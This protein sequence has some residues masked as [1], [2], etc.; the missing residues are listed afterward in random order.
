MLHDLKFA[1]RTLRTHPALACIVVVVL[2]LGIGAN[3][4]IFTLVNALLL[5]PPPH[6]Q[7]PHEL[8][9]LN[10]A[11]EYTVSGSFSY[12][13]YEFYRAHNVVFS[14][15]AAYGGDGVPVMARRGDVRLQASVM[16][17]SANFFEV[18]GVRAG[19]GRTFAPEEETRGPE[20]AVA[21][22]SYDFWR[23]RLGKTPEAVG[24]TLSLAGHPFTVVGVAPEGFRG[25]SPA[26]TAPDLFVP[27]TMQPVVF[28]MGG[29]MLD[30]I[31][32]E[33]QVWL[34]AVGRRA[35]GTG[36]EA[37][38]G[39]VLALVEQLEE[40]FPQW[41]EGQTASIT[42]HFEY[43]PALRTRLVRLLQLLFAVV[44]AVLLIACAN[45]AI[46]LLARAS[47]RRREFG[48]RLAIGAGRMRLVRQLMVESC[49]LALLAAVVGLVVSAWFVDAAAFLLP[50]SFH[51][52]L[53]P[54]GLVMGFSIGLALVTVLF[55]GVAPAW[56]ASRP[57]VVEELKGMTEGPDRSV[58]RS[59]LVVIQV[60]VSIVLVVAAGLFV[61][62]LNRVQSLDLGFAASNRLVVSMNLRSVGL[63]ADR[64]V[65]FLTEALNRIRALPGVHTATTASLIPF[66]GIWTTSVRAEGVELSAGQTGFE[67][68]I[69]RVGPDYFR[70]MGIPLQR[71]R[72]FSFADRAGVP[73]VAVVNQTLASQLW[74]EGDPVGQMIRRGPRLL[75]VIGIVPTVTYYDLGEDP[76]S[77]LYVPVLQ[78]YDP[79]ANLVVETRDDPRALVAQVEREL[80]AAQPDLI[81]SRSVTLS[82]IV[83]E[84]TSTFRM[85]ATLVSL[86]GFLAVALAAAGLYGVQSFLVT[87]RTREFGVRMALGARGTQVAVV[88]LRRAVKLAGIGI[89]VGLVGAWVGV[90]FVEGFLF[91]VDARDPM[92][93]AIVPV[94]VIAVA[95]LASVVPARR[96]SNIDPITALR[97]E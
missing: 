28:P 2:G 19:L 48:V 6:V 62:S 22:V 70:T 26:E 30:R 46:L 45:V 67:T 71:G 78:Q 69:N 42:Q 16:L 40:Q 50:G 41:N 61:R 37:V 49:V 13:D 66:R 64:G 52:D 39:N 10:R 18:L 60:A 25:V 51:L 96:A 75:R 34:Q 20:G 14:G 84:E 38:R 31:E 89:A 82:Q 57:Q 91:G 17:V 36:I 92:T 73:D 27:L 58:V 72:E 88:V 8:V 53:R 1:L 90:R 15:L 95:T 3:T 86:F 11:N 43:A 65:A 97:H 80:R 76:Q 79:V 35:P 24:T 94:T 81:I 4:T 77:Q 56:L 85:V 54:D 21:V 63:D 68:G 29:N 93:F 33:V 74:G 32:G 87:Q 47:G 7:A 44:A 9:R 83:R 12:P 5:Q 23:D 55:F 59:A